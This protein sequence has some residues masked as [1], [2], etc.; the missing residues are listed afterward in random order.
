MIFDCETTGLLNFKKPP[1][2]PGQPRLISLAVKMCEPGTMKLVHD[3]YAIV[4]PDGFTI[5]DEAARL[6]GITTEYA[7]RHG[8]PVED[9]IRYF[10]ALE[11]RT[12]HMVAY[13][14]KFDIQIVAG[15]IRRLWPPDM[16]RFDR[17]DPDSPNPKKPF[18]RCLMRLATRMMRL[19]HPRG[20]TNDF[21]WPKLS[22][23]YKWVYQQEMQGAHDAS[24]DALATYYL[25]TT[26]IQ[27]GW[28]DLE[29]DRMTYGGIEENLGE[30]P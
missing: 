26:A 1:T 6:H 24:V 20:Y 13:N 23:F 21:R 15:E 30:C 29:T 25:T 8:I 19:P 3:F 22:E 11:S 14:S 18:P 9:V 5:P 4:R 10:L 28:W 2:D 16:V 27:Q 7:E 12:G 17:C